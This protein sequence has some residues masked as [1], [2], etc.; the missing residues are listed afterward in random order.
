MGSGNPEERRRAPSLPESQDASESIDPRDTELGSAT[1]LT[2]SGLD[3]AAGMGTPAGSSSVDLRAEGGVMYL[4]FTRCGIVVKVT[5]SEEGGLSTL[6]EDSGIVLGTGS[7]GGSG[8]GDWD[9][10]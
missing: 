6:G 8:S 3:V 9:R 4:T 1:G 2:P 7:A 5:P 10:D